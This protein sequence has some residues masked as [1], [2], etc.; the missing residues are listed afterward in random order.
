MRTYKILN[1]QE[2][3]LGEYQITPIRDIDKYSI[4]KWRNEQIFHL[5]QQQPLTKKN[6]EKYFR[7]VVDNLFQHEKPNQLLFSY[8]RREK[9]IGYGGLVHIDWLNM[10]AEISFVMK[11]ELEKNQFA[12]HWTNFL[13]MLEKIAFVQLNLIKIYTYAFDLRPHLYDILEKNGYKREAKLKRHYNIN[14]NFV[15]VVIHSKHS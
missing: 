7:E 13:K 5:R 14:S 9:C 10:N 2:E 6:Q 4:M 12:V 3:N 15:D 8:L 11:T 1:N